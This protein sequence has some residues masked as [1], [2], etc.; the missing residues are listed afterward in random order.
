MD[1]NVSVAERNILAG[2][3]VCKTHV[4][5]RHIKDRRVKPVSSQISRERLRKF[6][7]RQ[8]LL[9]RESSPAV[10]VPPGTVPEF[11]VPPVVV[12]L[13][14]IAAVLAGIAD[15]IQFIVLGLEVTGAHAA[16]CVEHPPALG[17]LRVTFNR[18]PIAFR[19]PDND[20]PDRNIRILRCCQRG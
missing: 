9:L 17:S 16:A 12:M 15:D 1:R 8:P 19:V 3:G 5:Q 6:N 11:A 13:S 10:A 2:P 4:H 14:A 18:K 7:P 20:R